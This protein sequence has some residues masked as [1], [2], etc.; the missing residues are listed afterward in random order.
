M[1]GD[2]VGADTHPDTDT[3]SDTRSQGCVTGHKPIGAYSTH[4]FTHG[5]GDFLHAQV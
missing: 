1:D 2:M 3:N 5:H 4:T